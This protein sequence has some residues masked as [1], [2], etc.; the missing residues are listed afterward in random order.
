MNKLK[1]GRFERRFSI[2]K[3]GVLA[4]ARYAKRSASAWFLNESERRVAQKKNLSTEAAY[5]AEELGKLKG[6][7]VKI[8]QTLALWG[9]GFL[10]EEVTQALHALDSQTSPLDWSE[11]SLQLKREL[12]PTRLA[13]LYIES[14]PLGCAS[15]GQVHLATRLDCDKKICLKIQ[16][17]EVAES[18]D[19]DLAAMTYWLKVTRLLSAS[20]SLETWLDM[21]RE[22]LHNEV[23]YHQELAAMQ[24]FRHY[25]AQDKRYLVPEPYPEFSSKRVLA[26]AFVKG[27]PIN[28]QVVLTL[29]QNS[30]NAIAALMVE[31]F[32]NEC[33]IWGEMQ[34]D[35]NL[36][37]YLV[38]IINDQAESEPEVTL[39]LLDFGAV[40]QLSEPLIE[41][42]KAL[43]QGAI[44]LE[45]ETVKSALLQLGFLS[46]KTPDS[47]FI[48]LYELVVLALEPFATDRVYQWSHSDIVQ[49]LTRFISSAAFSRHF[50][51]PPR[52]LMFISRK[53]LGAYTAL[54]LLKAELNGFCM[55]QSYLK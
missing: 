14:E 51:L 31:L 17:P 42:G 37:N 46:E 12:G 43:V 38:K 55:L 44:A 35:P 10:P 47:V 39:V 11:I 52:E 8:G 30:R 4:G 24:R 29:P 6:G 18:I 36:G 45:K 48:A 28:S 49:R 27:Y 22:M 53:I 19:S 1:T 13:Q 40:F 15:F 3:A 32:W 20:Q 16:Y 7:V 41:V 9:E 26:S 5:F 33:L 23:D 50:Q 2:A 54:S 25:L 21:M 34:T